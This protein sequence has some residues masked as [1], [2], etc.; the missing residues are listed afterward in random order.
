MTIRLPPR[1]QR[2]GPIYQAIAD[3]IGREI[4]AGRMKPGARLPTQRL[5]ARQLGVTLTTVTRAY[6]EA[7]RRGLLNGEVGRGTFVRPTALEIEGPEHGLLD[8][9]VNSLLPLPYTEELADRLAAAIPRSAGA[10]VFGY[11]PN[12][13]ARHNRAAGSA[14][15]G[16][17]GLHAP[18][19]RV[20]VTAG[21]QH[22][23]L[24]ALMAIANPGDEILVEEFT[25]PGISDLA[26]HLHLR[27]RTVP[28]DEEG[29]QPD[30][31][32][33]AC[34]EGKPAALYCVPSFQNPTAA[35][36]SEA[37]RRAVAAVALRHQLTVIEDDVYG[38]LAPDAKP[39]STFLP[40]D[41]F[42]YIT[43]ASKSIAP[44]LRI[45]Y[46]LAPSA[47]IE[48]LSIAILR[49]VVNAPPAMAELA[50]SLITEGVAA[51]IVEWKRKEMAARQEIAVRVLRGLSMQ[52]HPMSPHLWLTLPEPWQTDAFLARARHR[53]ILLTGA[54]SFAVGR[55]TDVQAIRIA[56]G[57]A[58]T[59]SSLEEGLT[60]LMRI[61]QRAPEAY[62]LVV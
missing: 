42:F 18:V 59:R 38:Y 23:I 50:T 30:A 31:L 12:A 13:G 32:D 51:R 19:D 43:S 52:T 49:T 47:M 39:L 60:E 14:W 48:R 4:E 3:Q 53:G 35:L 9:A 28:L 29:I 37:R 33:Q 25:Y 17:T 58:A 62:E 10:R 54:E 16:Y 11:Q 36:M 24:I 20:V 8:F 41:N 27:L 22:A 2:S 26:A 40:E 45:G 21:G 55:R 5:L 44:G 7:Q 6:E 56:L 1:G 46:L 57:P 61:V 34:R 15:I